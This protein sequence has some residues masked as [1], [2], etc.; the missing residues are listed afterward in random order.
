MESVEVWGAVK[1]STIPEVRSQTVRFVQGL[2]A[3]ILGWGLGVPGH[4]YEW[5]Q[6]RGS[7]KFVPFITYENIIPQIKEHKSSNPFI[8]TIQIPAQLEGKGR[9]VMR[10]GYTDS[11]FPGRWAQFPFQRE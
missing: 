7:V 9:R 8:H 10:G 2:E 11:S 3:L 6:Q 4:S 1:L 5:R